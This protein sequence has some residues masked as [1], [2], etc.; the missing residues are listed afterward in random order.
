VV[1]GPGVAATLATAVDVRPVSWFAI[2]AGV[3]LGGIVGNGGGG[4]V[5]ASLGPIVRF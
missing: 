3:E 5:S 4:L 2:R 1:V